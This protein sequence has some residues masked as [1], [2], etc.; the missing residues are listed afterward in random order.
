MANIR[1][2]ILEDEKP[3]QGVL[4][5]YIDEVPYLELAAVHSNPLAAMETLQEDG[6]DLIFLD[7]NL[8]KISGLNFLKSLADPPE[9]IV[10]TAYPDYAL[11]GFELNVAD[12]LLK[13]ISFERFLKA[14][15]SLQG[16]GSVR[17]AGTEPAGTEEES[18]SG[19]AAP[20]A[21]GHRTHR[22]TFEKADNTIYKIVYDRIRYI[23]SD[24]DYV[25]VHLVDG[26]Y[27]FRQSLKYWLEILP[28][29]DFAQVHK[30]YIVNIS[31]IRRI[32]GNRIIME[33]GNL[34]IGR[35]Y[36]EDFL[37]KINNVN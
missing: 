26:E 33:D 23:E 20:D 27:M 13:P 18:E 9:V 2:L 14:V 30:S 7:I 16:S 12:Y 19:G 28:E 1:C 32:S 35:N 4:K 29:A 31:R 5:K 6:I 25:K 11:E 3:A 21:G 36:K 10:T 34:P 24:R 17:P 22:Y 37:D 15:S 8:P